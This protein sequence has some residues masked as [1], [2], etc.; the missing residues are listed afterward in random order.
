M[1]SSNEMEQGATVIVT[2]RVH[3]KHQ[4]NYEI[5]LREI[6]SVCR[7][8]PGHLD[9]QVVRPIHGMTST[10]TIVIRFDTQDNLQKWVGSN[11]RKSFIL[12]AAPL[13][14]KGD[15]LHFKSGIDFWFTPEGANAKLPKRWKQA[16]LTWSALFPVGVIT[17][18]TCTPLL[19]RL[20]FPHQQQLRT[21]ILSGVAIIL[22]VYVVM[23]RYTKFA[24]KWLFK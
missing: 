3:D 4:Q 6:S 22:M 8:Y 18:L 24:Q 20:G 7:S 13:L 1:N 11:D 15:Q 2:H 21:L 19:N 12:K 5:W 23:P 10:Y 16:L 14:D 17:N 9:L